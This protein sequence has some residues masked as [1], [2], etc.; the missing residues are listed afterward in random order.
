MFERAKH[1]NGTARFPEELSALEA[2]Q[3]RHL[4]LVRLVARRK[5]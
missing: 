2:D 5:S 1:A 3:G 4:G